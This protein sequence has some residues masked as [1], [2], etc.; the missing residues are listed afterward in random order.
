MTAEEVWIAR[1]GETDWSAAGRHTGRTDLELNANG[2]AA[3]ATL[4]ELL[5]GERFELVLTSPLARARETCELAGYGDAAEAEPD[6]REWDY[7][8]Y[9]GITTAEIRRTRPGWTTFSDDFPNGETLAEVSNRLDRVITRIR[10]VDGRVLVFGHGHALRIL[11]ARWID[12]EPALGANLVLATATL[13]IL[14]W[15]R[16]TPAIRRWNST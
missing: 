1:H 3:A 12:A 9:E 13:S 11:A 7:G 10:Q 16:E 5:A 2:R 6:L 14:G 15:E 8:D 4:G